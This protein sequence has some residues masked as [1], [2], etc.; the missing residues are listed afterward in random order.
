VPTITYSHTA[1]SVFPAGFTP[2]IATA[3]DAYGNTAKALVVV[4]VEP[5][6]RNVT[7][8][9][10]TD[11]SRKV[12]VDYDLLGGAARVG[13]EVSLDRGAT[14][15][16]VA[17]VSGAVGA[18]VS[19]GSGQRITWDAGADDPA[20]G[21]AEVR[22]RVT[23]RSTSQLG[24]FSGIPSGAYQIGDLTGDGD[25]YLGVAPVTSVSLSGFSM[26]TTPTTKQQWDLVR[27]W[28]LSHGYTD[29]RQVSGKGPDHPVSSV[30]WYEAVKWLN[31]ASEKEGLTPC[32]WVDGAVFRTGNS[33]G[34]LCIWDVT[35]YRLPTEA[36][37]EVA[38]RGGQ[39]GKRFPWGDTIS[40][41]QANY[42][43]RPANHF[44]DQGPLGRPP[45]Y[46][47]GSSPYTAPVG[48]FPANGYGL[49]D[50][51]GNVFQW[52][53]DKVGSYQG[54]NNPRGPSTGSYRALRGGAWTVEANF[55]RC[56]FRGAQNPL[57]FG[58]SVSGGTG[59]LGFRAAQGVLTGSAL[60]AGTSAGAVD[61]AAPV[62]SG[63]PASMS[64][65]ATSDAGAV[66]DYPVATALD[67]S[68]ASPTLSYSHARGTMFAVG[69]TT[70]TVTA[71]DSFGNSSTAD[72]TVTVLAT[73]PSITAPPAGRTVTEGETVWLSVT[74]AGTGPLSYQWKKD[75][76]DILGATGRVY[77]F[78]SA[79]RDNAGSYT[80]VVTS[81]AGSVTSQPAL[82]TVVK[83]GRFSFGRAVYSQAKGAGETVVPVTVRRMIDGSE[84]ASVEVVASSERLPDSAYALPSQP[85]LVR[86]EAGELGDKTVNLVL[87]KGHPVA[88]EGASIQLRL[89]SP[90]G[91]ELGEIGVATVALTP[92][93]P[94]VLMFEAATLERVKPE[95]GDLT[96]AL[97]VRRVQGATGAVSVEVESVGGNAS[98]G[99]SIIA[100]PMILEWGDGDTEPKSFP[101][102]VKAAA[103]VPAGG[104]TLK[105]RLR[106]ASGG[107]EVGGQGTASLV[108]SPAGLPGS[109]GFAAT[110]F[111]GAKAPSGET[112]VPVS[113]VR[114]SGGRGLVSVQV[115]VAGG[116]AIAG[117]DYVLAAP[118]VLTWADAELGA[119]TFPI[120]IPEGAQLG[121][122]GKTVLLKL[123]EVTGGV[124]FGVSRSATVNLMSGD[125]PGP[126]VVV[127]SP[128]QN[129]RVAGTSVVM[130]GKATDVSGV[131]RVTVSLNGA[132]PEEAELTQAGN[133]NACEWIVTLWP[134]QGVN[135]ATVLAY[136]HRG[137]VSPDT[138]L[139]FT[140]AHVRPELAGTYDGLLVPAVTREELSGQPTAAGV[141][142]GTRGGGLLAVSVSSAGSV[143]GRMTAGGTEQAFKGV[144]KRDGTVV[145][146]GG[147][148]K[149]AV[150]RSEGR[151]S[152][153]LGELS[154]RLREGDPA[155]VLGELTVPGGGLL[156]AGIEAEKHVYSAAK[157]LPSGMRRIPEEVLNPGYENGRYTVLFE[158]LSDEGTETNSGLERSGFP[159]GAGSG[160][161][162]V[163]SAGVV[164]VVGRLAD[165]TPISYTNRLS[166]K[167]GWPVYVPIYGRRG[168]LAGHVQFDPSQAESDAAC[169]A[170]E[171][172][173]PAGLAAPYGAG[174]PGG[175]SVGFAA[176]KY[177]VPS[178]P[179]KRLPTP[180]NPFGVFGSTVPV[181]AIPG[182]TAPDFV[183]VE[184]SLSGGGLATPWVQEATVNGGNALALVGAVPEGSPFKAFKWTFAAADGG[185]KGT[186]VHPVTGRIVSF[187][188][189]TFQ[190]TRR[191]AGCF[192]FLPANGAGASVGSV[193]AVLP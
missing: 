46:A 12:D 89:Q 149:W 57:L 154:L 9:Q 158:A 81:G 51:A 185:L 101:V 121:A 68:S 191:A 109:V 146:N 88:P 86:W 11:G 66:V 170:M 49:K 69:T 98:A 124:G 48:S 190:K 6:I 113:V 138:A 33:S 96:V 111:A 122:K 137:N 54:G 20:L 1:G 64:V 38:A 80:V 105:F 165:A 148:E 139:R 177:A 32:Y 172:L 119:K 87:R 128:R 112:V 141:F 72:F 131:V 160:Q 22:L 123:K 27:E 153:Q 126:V 130:R 39:V 171:W 186:F 58:S 56:A 75:G 107:A 2:V 169:T 29:L 178:A 79:T 192:Q 174:W 150:K 152:T 63:V 4:A 30:N 180:A 104:K 45:A 100:Q 10:R 97:A 173:R 74:A 144:L 179:T 151:G 90:T 134:E 71:T 35:G 15:R 155:V 36:E 44:Y 95:T 5:S 91:G 40:L 53:W 159:Q 73:A 117:G 193:E 181:N 108:L 92:R 77:T 83:P 156:L 84:P 85:T 19:P 118:V 147:L 157:V 26:A 162:T 167:L 18:F 41:S 47:V 133:G 28:G 183:P 99:D 127:E 175:I 182:D 132:D 120:R 3:T 187:T 82:M 76:A 78:S 102:L 16:S 145:F 17:S 188:G 166:P 42:N 24:A 103:T 21:N 14:Y 163:S 67:S 7:F 125:T 60:E 93:E 65:R 43:G 13:L 129:A 161:M 52:C 34:V 136:D 110:T 176:S 8:S 59:D 114:T 168:F 184:L 116:T 50:M 31:A 135:T 25:V 61:T 142:E 55:V 140:F 143:T 106:N 189:A 115:E 23:A 70:V 62:L 94:G 164:R 37:W